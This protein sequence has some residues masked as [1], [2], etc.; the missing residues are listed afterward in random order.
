[1]PFSPGLG[2]ALDELFS[3][4]PNM[5]AVKQ[6]PPGSS[7]PDISLMTLLRRQWPATAADLLECPARLSGAL[8]FN[9]LGLQRGRINY[10]ANADQQVSH[11]EM[12]FLEMVLAPARGW[13]S[14]QPPMNA[15]APE[16]SANTTSVTQ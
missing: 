9:C 2:W 6:M 15:D 14:L 8:I 16:E 12:A 5:G 7:L 10:N 1:L 11:M 4:Q 3:G 13:E